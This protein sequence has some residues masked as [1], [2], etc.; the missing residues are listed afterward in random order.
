MEGTSR[1]DYSQA[2]GIVTTSAIKGMM[3]PAAI[4]IVFPIVVGIISPKML[5]GLLIGTIVTGLFLAIS[6]TSGGGA[7]DN[8]KKL[9][10]DGAYGGKGSEAH[11]AW[12]HRRHRRRPVQGHGRP[13]DQPDDQDRE[14]RRDPDHPAARFDSRMSRREGV[15]ALGPPPLPVSADIASVRPGEGAHAPGARLPGD[16]GARDRGSGER[17]RG[18]RGDGGHLPVRGLRPGPQPR[19]ALRLRRPAR[20]RRAGA[21]RSRCRWQSAACSHSTS[22]SC[23]RCTRSPC[24]ESENWFALAV[25]SGTA[26]VVSELAASS[27]RRTVEAEQRRREAALLA[28]ISTDLLQGEAVRDEL[29]QIEAALRRGARDLRDADRPRAA[30]AAGVGERDLRS[31]SRRRGARSGRISAPPGEEPFTRDAAAVP[32]RAGVA[33]RRGR[34]SR[35]SGRQALEAEALRRSD[36]LKTALLRAVSH[37]LRSPLT[38]ISTAVGGLPEREP[39]ARPRRSRGAARDDRVESRRLERLVANLLDLSRLQAGAAEPVQ[40]LWAVDQLIAQALDQVA[41]ADRIEISIPDDVPVVL[42]D[43][44]QVERALVNLLEN[45]IKFSPPASVVSLRVTSTRRDAVIRVVDSGIRA[46]RRRSSSGSSSRSI[47]PGGA[48]AG[49]AGLGLAIVRGFA[50]AN[51]GR[52]WAESVARTGHVVRARTPRGAG[53]GDRP[54]ERAP[55][56]G[57]RR[58]RRAADPAR[59]PDDPTGSRLRRRHRRDRGG[60][61][62]RAAVQPPE[63]VIL[64]LVLPDGSGVEVCRELRTWTTRPDP[65]P[66][67]GRRGAREGCGARCRRRRLRDEAVRRRRAPRAPPCRDAA[68]RVPRGAGASGSASWSSISRSAR[69]RWPASRCS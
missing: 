64:D 2:V 38:A 50:E 66:L 17:S 47:V 51:G 55:A 52:V 23:L 18:G 28:D 9:I 12:N 40:E 24:T 1:P 10:E 16:D 7:W 37:D 48:T 6:M 44:I 34:R 35:A 57:A 41:E 8:A 19:R 54:H 53:G 56:Q 39:R 43:A 42:V 3:L 29:A 13:G 69:S 15:G 33:S 62:D 59:A 45:A 46:R 60:R 68:R 58:R 22:S 36:A 67:G 65:D 27:R 25:Y 30:L 20:G 21:W 11:A 31:R 61:A 63:A 14:H 49:G 32:A 5:G 26:I 4:P